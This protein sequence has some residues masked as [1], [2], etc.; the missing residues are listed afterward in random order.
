MQE[1]KEAAQ[2]QPVVLDMQHISH[3]DTAGLAWL[4]NLMRD[5]LTENV[6]FSI[7]NAPQTLINLAKISDV[8]V[9]LPLQ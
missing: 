5:C 7:T 9:L 8:E 3:V 1:I 6:R 2:Q 4:I